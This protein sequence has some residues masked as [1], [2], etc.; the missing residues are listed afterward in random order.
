MYQTLLVPLD[1]SKFSERALP[2]AV[3]LAKTMQARMVLLHVIGAPVFPGGDTAEV[4]RQAGEEAQA[5]LAQLA[6]SL[7]AED[8]QVETVVTY[9]DAAESLLLEVN[10]HGVDLVVMCSHG[11]SGLGRWIFG[12]VAERV[13]AHSAVPVLLVRPTGKV[14]SLGP[15]SAQPSLLVPLDGSP[16]AEAALPHATTLARAFGSS[17][18]LLRS[19]EPSRLAYHYSLRDLAHESLEREKHEAQ[20]YLD[21]VA[22]RLGTAGIS[23]Q[24][25]VLVGW[26]SD[27]ISY[28]RTA[29][30]PRLVVMATHG[31]SGVAR[32][33]LGSVA[34][35][36]IRR[37][38]LPIL[39]VR[40]KV[41]AAMESDPAG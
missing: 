1:G 4:E 38:P 29:L 15:E 31:R 36:V 2:M 27:V 10:S 33:I 22:E 12:S 6:R 16:L 13:L 26:P 20:S 18:L 7:L 35:E 5:Y 40:P 14:V 17:I 39:L 28:R 37:S 3:I 19:V 41:D 25:L 24:T 21:S 34:L 8:L 30:E 32:L 9:G 23:A 11:R